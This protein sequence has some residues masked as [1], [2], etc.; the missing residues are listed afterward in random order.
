MEAQIKLCGP[1]FAEADLDDNCEFQ[2]CCGPDE[3]PWS[4]D[5]LLLEGFRF[6]LLEDEATM[7]RCR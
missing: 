5:A 6:G 1:C 2:E 4:V 3:A 7:A